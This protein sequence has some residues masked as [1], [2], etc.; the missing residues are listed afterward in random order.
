MPQ[1]GPA[2]IVACVHLGAGCDQQLGGGVVAGERG[3]MQGGASRG[4]VKQRIR[5]GG[6]EMGEHEEVVLVGGTHEQGFLVP[7]PR[8]DAGAGQI[9]IQRSQVAGEKERLNPGFV[10]VPDELG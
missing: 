1:R 5:T 8:I 3:M 7:A 2:V 4:V 10:K 9:G 6:Q